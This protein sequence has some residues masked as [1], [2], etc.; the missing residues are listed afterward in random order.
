MPE[1]LF[2]GFAFVDILPRAKDFASEAAK[3]V[4]KTEGALQQFS[5]IGK[6]AL[7]GVLG[8]VGVVGAESIHLADD[9]EG[10]HA[11]LVTALKNTGTSFKAVEPQVDSLSKRME[12]LGFSNT[13]VQAN[14]AKLQAAT[15]NSAKSF[16]D[17][18]LAADVARGRHIDLSSAVDLV[19]KV[20]TGHVALLGRIG[21]ATKD[22]SGHTISQAEAIKRLTAL[23]H[24]QAAAAAATFAGK[25]QTLRTQAENLGVQ[26]GLKLIPFVEKL[27]GA[28]EHAVTWL[29]K[30]RAIAEALGVAIGSVLVTAIAAYAVAMASAAVATIAA[31]WP[32]LAII[33]AVALVGVAIFELATHWRQVW[34][35]IK[36]WIA[37][38][39]NW[40]KKHTGFIIAAFG[41]VG[42][43]VELLL[44]NWKPIW[45]AIQTAVEDAWK[46]MKPIFEAIKR[47]AG[48]V[49]SAIGKVAGVAKSA[50]GLLSHIPGLAG[51]GDFDAGDVRWVG[52]RGPE[53]A[54]FGKSGTV[55]P[56]AASMRLVSGANTSSAAVTQRH[57]TSNTWAI[58]VNASGR[59]EGQAAGKAF[60]EQVDEYFRHGGA[61]PEHWPAASGRFKS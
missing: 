59:R 35:D 2:A 11:R 15:K 18:A 51:G 50:G 12:T 58:T 38:A 6:A 10:A 49:G 32:I 52:E 29:E 8:A 21:I 36:Q 24:G 7:A 53:L 55:L 3:E 48:D 37:D 27:V 41:P 1:G 34:S 22:A 44:H 26:I 54:L 19:T 5:G 61:A 30:H 14:L 9:F 28:V 42:V 57:A 17:M 60:V 25:M 13:D 16:A 39:V 20:E 23:Y 45:A 47:A 56:N 33:A 46:I 40:I 4:K 43:A 31:T